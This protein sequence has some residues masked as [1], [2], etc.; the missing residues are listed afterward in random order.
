MIELLFAVQNCP[1]TAAVVSSILV[2]I[3]TSLLFLTIGIFIGY[4]IHKHKFPIKTLS[5]PGL[6]KPSHTT[7]PPTN[8]H[9]VDQ[10]NLKSSAKSIANPGLSEKKHA[11]I[12][13]SSAQLSHDQQQPTFPAPNYA[14]IHAKVEEH[15]QGFGMK[16]C[17]AYGLSSSS[18]SAV[19]INAT[20][21]LAAQAGGQSTLV[22]RPEEHNYSPV[23]VISDNY[24]A[25][26]K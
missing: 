8:K 2:F 7:T 11:Q 1:V 20:T 19:N 21:A 18:Q 16:K 9:H 15:V 3:F 6:D 5:T 4:F 26:H 22:S 14:P 24:V 10:P 17:E 13:S 25:F 23:Q 12:T